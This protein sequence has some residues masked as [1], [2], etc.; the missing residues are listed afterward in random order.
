[1][2]PFDVLGELCRRGESAEA[3]T[4]GGWVRR[5]VTG[6]VLRM[7]LLENEALLAHVALAEVGERHGRRQLSGQLCSETG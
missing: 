2:V 4:T 5:P 7:V 1:M 6:H 3:A